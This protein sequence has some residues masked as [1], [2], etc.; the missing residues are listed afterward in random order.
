[1]DLTEFS[2][3]NGGSTPQFKDLADATAKINQEFKEQDIQQRASSSKGQYGYIDIAR[4]PINPDL[5]YLLDANEAEEA[6]IIPFF[7]IGMKLRVAVADP[8]NMQTKQVIEK[9]IASN[10][11]V[12][13]NLA[14]AEGIKK[15]LVLLH[16][17]QNLNKPKIADSFNENNLEDYQKELENLSK[18]AEKIGLSSAKEGLN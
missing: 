5:Y 17:A 13:I 3:Q 12:Q 8:E 15:A 1:M 18:L 16:N 10:F 6:L 2:D 9:L 14:S 4:T 11:E 7:R